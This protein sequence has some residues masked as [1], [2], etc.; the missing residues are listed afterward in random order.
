M[1][2]SE[3]NLVVEIWEQV[4]EYIPSAKRTEIAV[5]FIKAFTDFGFEKE[6]FHDIVD[7]DDNL[8][9]AYNEFFEDDL[10]EYEDKDDE[11]RWE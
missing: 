7:E 5:S 10:Y 9:A 4:R 8:N 3:S 2:K 6:D 1:I 11:I